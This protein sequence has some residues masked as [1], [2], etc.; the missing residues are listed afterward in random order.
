[1][2]LVCGHKFDCYNMHIYVYIDLTQLYMQCLEFSHIHLSIV[3]RQ[4]CIMNKITH[5][6]HTTNR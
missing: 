3:R 4:N 6:L 2:N 1:M 5:N